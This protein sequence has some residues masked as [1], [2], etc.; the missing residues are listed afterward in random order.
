MKDII[1]LRVG[2]ETIPSS[3]MSQVIC[4]WYFFETL[5]KEMGSNIFSC[6]FQCFS[7]K[8]KNSL[9]QAITIAC[10]KIAY[11]KIKHF[12]SI[13]PVILLRKLCDCIGISVDYAGKQL[14]KLDIHKLSLY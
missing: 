2:T 14:V 9:V 8:G 6:Y 11:Q 12:A 5:E 10:L 1:L 4:I 13:T 7:A 3:P